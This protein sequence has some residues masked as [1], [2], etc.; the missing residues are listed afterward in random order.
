MVTRRHRSLTV[1]AL[2][3][4]ASEFATHDATEG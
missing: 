2:Q 3:I 1:T 4:K